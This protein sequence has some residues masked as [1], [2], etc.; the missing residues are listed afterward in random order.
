M[1]IP[2][3]FEPEGQRLM[4]VTREGERAFRDEVLTDVR[5]VPLIG[6]QGYA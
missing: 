4:R 5:F 6:A 2:V 1:V 3:G